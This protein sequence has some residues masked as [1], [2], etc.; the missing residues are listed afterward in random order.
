MYC[1]STCMEH[2]I[3]P[4]NKMAVFTHFE[5]LKKLHIWNTFHTQL[6]FASSCSFLGWRGIC[7]H[8]PLIIMEYL[9]VTTLSVCSVSLW[10]SKVLRN[11]YF[12]LTTPP[13]IYVG[14]WKDEILYCTSRTGTSFFVRIYQNVIGTKPLRLAALFYTTLHDLTGIYH[15]NLQTD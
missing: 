2:G 1:V 10:H 13:S 6:C 14:K 4:F 5:I 9:G 15:L 12:G 8:S 7:A 3:E 11:I